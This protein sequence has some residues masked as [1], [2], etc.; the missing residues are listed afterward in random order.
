MTKDSMNNMSGGGVVVATTKLVVASP[1]AP[2]T[3]T[4][5]KNSNTLK[6]SLR[7]AIV[8]NQKEVLMLED[9]V[10]VRAEE[11]IM[12][13][14][15]ITSVESNDDPNNLHCMDDE[16]DL[17]DEE[18][19]DVDQAIL[20]VS[21]LSSMEHTNKSNKDDVVVD[22]AGNFSSGGNDDGDDL[23]KRRLRKRRRAGQDLERLEHFQS[24]REG[25]LA[26]QQQPRN[27]AIVVVPSAKKNVRIKDQRNLTARLLRS[28]PTGPMRSRLPSISERVPNPLSKF[29][30][31]IAS[32]NEITISQTSAKATFED[33]DTNFMPI[34]SDEP[35]SVSVETPTPIDI[36]RKV[37]F[38]ET[39]SSSSSL[40][41]NRMR[42][43]S[44]DLDCES[45]K[46]KIRTFFIPSSRL[47]IAV[48][49]SHLNLVF[50]SGYRGS[51]PRISR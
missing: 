12:H 36:A 26:R 25:G 7:S 14:E 11:N 48:S 4:S 21:L 47:T 2:K 28:V 9:A 15:E 42:G 31:H 30:S 22:D 34:F 13:D 37:N 51:R 20:T 29:D 5:N 27:P 24:S 1:A 19:N 38:S 33:S 39:S 23:P 16:D 10:L 44:I 6:H 50:C 46:E 17:D 35:A 43:L 32:S 45:L 40:M 8:A 41:N 3:S 18:E 49:L